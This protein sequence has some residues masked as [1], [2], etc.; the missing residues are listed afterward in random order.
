MAESLWKRF[1][2][3][4]L[5]IEA[6]ELERLERGV[7]RGF[8]RVT[9]VVHLRGWGE[10]G[11]GEDVTWYTEAHDREQAAGAILPLAGSWTLESFSAALDVPE[12]HRRWAYES[13]ALDLALRQA[14]QPLAALVGRDPGPVSFVVSPGLGE[15]PT[16]RTVRRWLEFDPS[17]RF[18]LDPATSWSDDLIAELAATRAVVTADLKAFYRGEND[19]PPDPDLYRRVAEGFRE[20]WLEDPALTEATEPVLEPHRDR[21]TWDAPI[22]SIADVEALPFPPR[23]LNCKPS[24]FGFLRELLDFYDHCERHRIGLYGGGMFELGPGRGQV[25]YLAS[26]FH[27]DAPNDVAPG[28]YNDPKPRPGLPPSPLEP[29]PAPTGFRWASPTLK[30]AVTRA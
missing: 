19:L 12:P 25:Q 30:G 10:E 18:K 29:A 17:L 27:P 9:T 5:E 6:Y 15:P 28:A 22:H 13:A 16:S 3:L 7:T 24:R 26:L 2:E 11:L 8:T 23:T 20:A 14:R 1:A 4:P 21:V